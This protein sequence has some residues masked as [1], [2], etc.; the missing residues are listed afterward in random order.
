MYLDPKNAIDLKTFFDQKVVQ[1]NQPAFIAND[2]ICIPHRFTQL[3]DI[4]IAGFFAALFAWGNRTIIINKTTELLAL[5][6]NAPYE[7]CKHHQE[8]DLKKFL[9]FKHRTFQATDVLYLIAFLQFHYLQSHSL[10][11]AFTRWMQ[12]NDTTIENALNGFRQYVFSFMH[13]YPVR[14]EK[15][16]AAPY[17]NATCKRLCMYLR[18]MV[19]KDASHVDFG[20]WQNI[21]P[22][23]LVCPIDLHVASVAERF[24]LIPKNKI[25]W[26]TALQLTTYLKMLDPTDPVKYDFALFGLGVIEKY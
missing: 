26:Q 11:T 8:S 7:F 10:Q 6:D 16:I 9:N 1:Y 23:Q 19:R 15:H 17:K 3:Q 22:S 2:P 5:M 13:P 14:T 12:P 24:Q 20:L 25:N 21:S 4:E 18:W